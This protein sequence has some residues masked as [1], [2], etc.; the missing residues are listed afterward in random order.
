M[1]GNK[2]V[3]LNTTMN[4]AIV[5]MENEILP[6]I[7]QAKPHLIELGQSAARSKKLF[8]QVLTF[9]QNIKVNTSFL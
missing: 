1:L 2:L 5:L 9:F 4:D 6:W 3:E 8:E 7:T